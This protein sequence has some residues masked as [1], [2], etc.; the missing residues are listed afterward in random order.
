MD[1][2]NELDESN[3]ILYAARHYY[4]PRCIDA[5]EFYDDINRF[6]YIKRLVNRYNRGGD[7]GE[8]LLLNHLTVIMNVFGYEAGLKMLEY[9]IGLQDWDVIKPFLVFIRAIKEDQY[10]GMSMDEVVV[11][12]LRNI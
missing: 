9:K 10:T 7:L 11:D 4:S 1:L 12:K 3:F 2:F 5:E 6:K 8:R